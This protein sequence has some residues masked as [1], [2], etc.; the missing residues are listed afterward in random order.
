VFGPTPPTPRVLD[1]GVETIIVTAGRALWW[2][3][4]EVAAGV[5][6]TGGGSV[7]R[8]AKIVTEFADA[9]KTYQ[10]GDGFLANIPLT[11]LPGHDFSA[12]LRIR[13]FADGKPPGLPADLAIDYVSTNDQQL[14]KFNVVEG[15]DATAPNE[16][17]PPANDLDPLFRHVQRVSA[18]GPT[19]DPNEFRIAYVHQPT[20]KGWIVVQPP[21][22]P[23]R[24]EAWF[25]YELA[26]ARCH[27][28]LRDTHDC[29][30]PARTA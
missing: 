12:N 7:V 1:S 10:A 13:V 26:C 18:A 11:E 20:Q 27:R 22:E 6:V 28:I 23:T 3:A 17:S 16:A 30:A 2:K 5:A 25:T 14:D 29:D 19:S 24:C 15:A 4:A 21:S 9:V 8:V